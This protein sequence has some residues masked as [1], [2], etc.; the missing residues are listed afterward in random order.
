[1]NIELT[2][3]QGIRYK[4][5]CADNPFLLRSGG[6]GIDKTGSFVPQKRKINKWIVKQNNRD[7]LYQLRELELSGANRKTVIERIDCRIRK[8]ILRDA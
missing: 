1:M 2:P 6:S 8:L 4:L 5:L 3:A 7:V